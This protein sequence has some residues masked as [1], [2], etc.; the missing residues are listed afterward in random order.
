MAAPVRPY[1]D[2]RK[3]SWVSSPDGPLSQKGGLI[4]MELYRDCT[5]APR[6]RAEDLC[7]RMTLREKVGQLQQQLYGFR[8]AA[9]EGQ[10]IVLSQELRSTAE[11]FGGLGFLYGMLRADPW[12]GRTKENGLRG[13]D[14]VRAYNAVQRMSISNSRFGIPALMTGDCPHGNM[15][16]DGYLLPVN[17]AMGSTFDPELVREAAYVCAKQLRAFGVHVVCVSMLD[18]LR[19]PRWGRCEEC[20][21][22]DPYAA[23]AL[24]KAAV[25]GYHRAGV[26][27]VAKHLC[28]QGET[29]GGINASPARLGERELREIHLPVVKAVCEAGVDAFMAAYNEIDGVP[30]HANE[31]LLNDLIRDEY[32]FDGIVMA[33][34]CAVDRLDL[35][36]GDNTRSGAMAL[37]AGVDVG[38]WDT[39]FSRLEEAVLQGWVSERRLNEAVVR[40]LTLKFR[41]GLFEHPYLPEQEEPETFAPDKY[42]QSL[43]LAQEGVVLLKNDGMLPLRPQ[44]GQR[45]ALIGPAADDLYRQLGDYTP[46]MDEEAC[47]TLAKGLRRILPE[48]VILDVDDGSDTARAAALAARADAVILALGSSSSRYGQVFFDQTGAAVSGAPVMDCGEGVDICRL[49]LSGN[50]NEL[51]ACVRAAAAR[52]V[53]VLI[54]GRPYA[55]G[56]IA[57]DSDALLCTFYPGPYGGLALAQAL[58]GAYSPTGRLPVSFPHDASQLPVYYNKKRSD[59]IR[60]YADARE[61]R[62]PLFSFGDGMGYSP[63]VYSEIRCE[64]LDVQGT[65]PDDTPVVRVRATVENQ[66]AYDT[67]ALPMLFVTDLEADM[68]RREAELHAFARIPVPAGEK[69]TAELTLAACDLA[70]WN[71]RMQ[72]E[73]Q[74]GQYKLTLK[75]GN[76][77]EWITNFQFIPRKCEESKKM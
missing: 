63:L 38:L 37:N 23:A 75:D 48:K 8:C 21:G 36:T 33:D 49:E 77:A 58:C 61:Q 74:P 29:T 35:L 42:P 44:A 28:A 56:S 53:T 12:S 50:Q 34:G 1:L 51:F 14:A 67:D 9:R 32:G 41:L 57:R 18:M 72:F 10:E 62:G 69:R 27:V 65:K 40:V 13:R 16:L 4:K 19:D 7:S 55:V 31:W 3:V 68:T 73:L 20:Y 76:S 54:L 30:C 45:I 47:I 15:M 17:L 60:T 2:T 39:A 70:C 43:Q 52:L 6:A 46:P 24:A 66:G 64:A 22:E 26:A 71:R 25:E 59:R 5:K 11:H